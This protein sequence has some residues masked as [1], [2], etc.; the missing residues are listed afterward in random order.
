MGVE[1]DVNRV[2]GCHLLVVHRLV[3][4]NIVGLGGI[5]AHAGERALVG[6]V[7]ARG[8]GHGEVVIGIVGRNAAL[9]IAPAGL[10]AGIDGILC[11]PPPLA[12]AALEGEN[13]TAV[14]HHNLLLGAVDKGVARRGAEQVH[15]LV[16]A[17]VVGR[18]AH[19]VG[20]RTVELLTALV[21]IDRIVGHQ[22]ILAARHEL[23][24]A[25]DESEG[26]ARSRST[27]HAA[28]GNNDRQHKSRK[29][30]HFFL[31]LVN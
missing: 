25:G 21:G 15:R 22:H 14:G 24:L 4:H 20:R 27:S 9:Q 2:G 16:V 29:L 23:V 13:G 10:A 6:I 3:V 31:H 8:S 7:R 11:K 17:V 18:A 30:V 28:S 5:E 1:G 26:L 12:L 19:Q